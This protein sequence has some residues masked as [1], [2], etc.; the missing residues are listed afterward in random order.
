MLS[1]ALLIVPAALKTGITT[2]TR[3]S[4]DAAISLDASNGSPSADFRG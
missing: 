2:S 4:R 3:R 1:I